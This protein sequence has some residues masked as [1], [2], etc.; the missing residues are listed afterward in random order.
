MNLTDIQNIISI[1]EHYMDDEKDRTQFTFEYITWDANG[2][3]MKSTATFC[4]TPIAQEE[5][6]S[7]I[8]QIAKVLERETF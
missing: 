2:V 6:L 7:G 4:L 3:E 8:K 5:I 1:T